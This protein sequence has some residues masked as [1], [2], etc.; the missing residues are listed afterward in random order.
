MLNLTENEKMVDDIVKEVIEDINQAV[1]YYNNGLS[2]TIPSP[3]I[4]NQEWVVYLQN[5]ESAKE[6][7]FELEDAFYHKINHNGYWFAPKFKF[8]ENMITIIT[9]WEVE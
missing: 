8:D 7:I 1:F 3:N 2:E 9:N 6:H 4:E 5:N